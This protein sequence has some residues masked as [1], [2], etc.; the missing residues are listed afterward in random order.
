MDKR[1]ALQR[2]LPVAEV[3]VRVIRTMDV[4]VVHAGHA[5]A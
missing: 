5:P 1:L 2:A 4:L 3:I